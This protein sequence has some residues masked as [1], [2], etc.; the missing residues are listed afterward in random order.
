MRERVKRQQLI[1][2]K[3]MAAEELVMLPHNSAISQTQF[4]FK[5]DL[6]EIRQIPGHSAT[7]WPK[8]EKKVGNEA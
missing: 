3:V 5:V 6:A 4:K 7:A 1:M 8:S 2:I